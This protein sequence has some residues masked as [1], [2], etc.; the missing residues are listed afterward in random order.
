[1][2]KG[3]PRVGVL[4]GA[5]SQLQFDVV[6]EGEGD[7]E[8]LLD[9]CAADRKVLSEFVDLLPSVPLHAFGGDGFGL[10]EGIELEV[11][12]ARLQKIG[13]QPDDLGGFGEPIHL[14]DEKMEDSAE[15]RS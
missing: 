5:L 12:K 10:V 7:F 6:E 1:M 3:D 8:A 2:A 13:P 4:L 11:L 14:H 9:Q 15:D